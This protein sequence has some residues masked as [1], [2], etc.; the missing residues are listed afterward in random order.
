MEQENKG[1]GV[2]IVFV[3][4]I[5]YLIF[6][7]NKSN[8]LEHQLEEKK[9]ELAANANDLVLSKHEIVLLKNSLTTD[10]V[11]KE[12][13]KEVPRDRIKYVTKVETRLISSDPVYVS[14]LPKEYYFKTKDNLVVASILP[15]NDSFALD[16]YD[17]DIVSNT[18]ILDS[19][20]V[21]STTVTSSYDPDFTIR[22]PSKTQT[23]SLPVRKIFSPSIGL[24]VGLEVPSFEPNVLLW[25]TN[26][27]LKNFDLLGASVSASQGSFGFGIVPLAYNIGAPLPL[28]DNFWLGTDL[29][30]S[31]ANEQQLSLFLGAQL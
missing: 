24:G 20:A 8:S 15:D 14:E 16:T 18:V 6:L 27:H 28:F 25:N 29:H 31:L 3:L 21:T 4:T 26:I 2:L 9:F 19:Q 5:I 23:F 17:L 1:R 12:I 30:Y 22:L 13:I 11:I 10:P 7:F